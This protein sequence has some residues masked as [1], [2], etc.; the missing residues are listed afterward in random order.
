[1]TL[2]TPT[3][4]DQTGF[5]EGFANTPYEPTDAPAQDVEQQ[6]TVEPEVEYA[7]ITRAQFDEL[8]ALKA[9]QDKSFGTFGRTIKSIQDQ[10]T[11]LASG[12]QVDIS[13][14]DIDSLR[15]DFPPLAAALEKVRSLR[16]LPS[17]GVDASKL[18]EL[19]QQRLAPALDDIESRVNHAVEAKLL[20]KAH[21]DWKEIDQSP[22][23]ATWISAQ[24]GGFAEKLSAASL[25]YDSDFVSDAITKFK[26]SRKTT[27]TQQTQ[28]DPAASRRNRMSA[29]ITPRGSGTSTA[30]SS[31]MDEF[32]SGFNQG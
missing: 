11:G 32:N 27:T 6:E 10:V 28:M 22:A 8:M 31:A 4:I 26:Q 21:A 5:D 2:E 23:F 24:P 12:P 18:D 20:A 3:E 15:E 1:M 16:A 7:Q 13:Q 30:G 17:A 14:D 19:V 9:S 29:A 25:A